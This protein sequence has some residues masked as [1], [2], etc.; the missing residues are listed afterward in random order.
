MRTTVSTVL[1][2]GATSS[3]GAHLVTLLRERGSHVRGLVRDPRRATEILGDGVGLAV[4]DFGDTGSIR[5]A[6]TGAETLFLACGNVADQVKYECRAIDEAARA[7]VHRIVKLS[8]RGADLD[9]PV[10]FWRWHGVIEQHL[11]ASGVPAVT[12]Q[13]TFSMTNLLGAADQVRHLGMLF[14]PAAAARIAM[15]HPA[16]VAAVA[17][18]ALTEDGHEGSSLVLTGPAAITYAQVAADLS[19]A[20]GQPVGYV[21]IAPEVAVSGL[22]QAGVPPFAAAQIVKVY[23]TLRDGGQAQTTPTVELITGQPARSFATYARDH[24]SVFRNSV[25]T[26]L[27]A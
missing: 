13:P 17:V 12:L 22:A 7:G 8:A 16:D 27:S 6:M 4:G 19:A 18:V 10:A 14:A 3:V 26:S 24:A 11:R 9:A 25:A 5:A 15:V 23:E 2:T 20:T 21:D 1:V